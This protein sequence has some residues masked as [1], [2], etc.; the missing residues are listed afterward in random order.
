M[1][2]KTDAN[3][4][5]E[6]TTAVRDVFPGAPIQSGEGGHQYAIT[7]M[8][9]NTDDQIEAR[10]DQLAEL[11][12]DVDCRIDHFDDF[13]PTGSSMHT[14]AYVDTDELLFE[15]DARAESRAAAKAEARA[16]RALEQ[17]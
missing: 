2:R 11:L 9:G 15:R 14:T 5:D 13:L 3:R 6:I 16:E 8:T 17:R 10:K 12:F 7:I 1:V 4:D